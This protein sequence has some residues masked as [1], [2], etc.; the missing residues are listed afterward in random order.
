[1]SK[2]FYLLRAGDAVVG[3]G[4][5]LGHDTNGDPGM[6]LASQ[7]ARQFESLEAASEFAQQLN[8]QFGIFE[9]E[10]RNSAD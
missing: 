2:T 3:N 4:P 10:V 7:D 9:I 8:E 1:M 5:Y 6:I